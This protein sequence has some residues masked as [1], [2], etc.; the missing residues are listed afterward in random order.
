MPSDL[1]YI[2]TSW[3]PDLLLASPTVSARTCTHHQGDGRYYQTLKQGKLGF[4]TA[5]GLSEAAGG[6]ASM[7][8]HSVIYHVVAAPMWARLTRLAKDGSNLALGK[9]EEQA[10]D[11]HHPELAEKKNLPA[12]NLTQKVWDG[13]SLIHSEC[14]NLD[15]TQLKWT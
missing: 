5:V 15:L 1:R 9:K 8:R 7:S 10:D 3:S 2:L 12:D 14:S 11:G 13:T 6:S 4:P